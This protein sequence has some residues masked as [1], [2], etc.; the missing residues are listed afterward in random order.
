MQLDW[1]LCVDFSGYFELMFD[2][3]ST[4]NFKK[5]VID[6]M[7]ALSKIINPYS[8]GVIESAY[9]IGAYTQ[10]SLGDYFMLENS[11]HP[12]SKE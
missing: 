1:S 3:S 10:K 7:K 2:L 9:G 4:E 6:T 11:F 5:E 12:F 8:T